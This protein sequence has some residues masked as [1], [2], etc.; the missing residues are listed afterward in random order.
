MTDRKEFRKCVGRNA[1]ADTTRGDGR[2]L[3]STPHPQSVGV[4]AYMNPGSEAHFL[5]SRRWAVSD[6]TYWGAP[7]TSSKLGNGVYGTS[8]DPNRGPKLVRKDIVTDGLIELPDASSGIVLRE[9]ESFWQKRNVFKDHGFL[10]KRGYLLWGPPG[11]GKSS[12]LQLMMW[13]LVTAG[14]VV[15]FVD[16][17]PVATMCL[18]L[19]R[20]VEPDRPVVVIMED[21]DAIVQRYGEADLLAL[22]D[23]ES[24]IDGV[25]YLATTNYPERLDAR[26][27]DRPSRFDTITYFGMPS[28]LAR[29]TYFKAK[30]T[31]LAADASECARWV[32][33]SA[34]FSVAHLR[35]MLVA[36]RCLDQDL[37]HVVARLEE[38][39]ERK[40]T[41]D[42]APDKP[43]F[44]FSRGLNG[45]REM[46]V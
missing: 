27:V 42:D 25:V 2:I 26:F 17:P 45:H 43:T 16:H 41:S 21:I 13:Q 35:E 1:A 36:V 29:E 7:P 6:G 10:H 11:S 40:P 23:G 20:Q 14:G 24:Q 28:S 31:M 19:L 12:A 46:F 15:L 18:A 38:M 9:F 3:N 4:A 39:H 8:F 30:D 34:G 32:K 44:G 33:K 22:L 37:D 5:T